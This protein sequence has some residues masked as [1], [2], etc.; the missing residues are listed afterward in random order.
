MTN[1]K[2]LL[3]TLC[4]IIISSISVFSQAN[5]NNLFIDGKF[6]KIIKQSEI[7]INSVNANEL[8]YYW[9]A[10]SLHEK[11]DIKTAISTLKA[12][13]KQFPL[14][15]KIEQL[16]GDYYYEAGN[17]LM[18]KTIFKKYINENKFLFKLCDILEANTSYT[19]AIKILD[20][21]Y[22][23]DS[24]NISCLKHLAH[25]NYKIEDYN[26]AESYYK[27]LITILPNDQ[28][29]SRKLIS[30]YNEQE[31]YEESY[32]LCNKMLKI[33]PEN[34]VFIKLAGYTAIKNQKFIKAKELFTKVYMKGDS[35][36]Y[37]LKHLGLAKL[38]CEQY[39]EGQEILH[40][41]FLK[42]TSDYLVCYFLGDSYL[43]T[44]HRRKGI[45]YIEKSIENLKP[46]GSVMS[47]VLRSNAT[48]HKAIKE[49]ERAIELYLEAFRVGLDPRDIYYAASV[50][51]NG[52]KDYKMALEYFQL[53]L[54]HIS[55]E[56]EEEEDKQ[57]NNST[58][59]NIKMSD[60]AKR[61]IEEIKTE[62]FFREGK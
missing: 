18:A 59:I 7:N 17:L 26:R 31:R 11:G 35:S 3:F 41:A 34:S 16:I 6:E 28:F 45:E 55:G 60:I 52:M 24:I 57:K 20:K 49:Y 30:I 39:K 46:K 43:H 37:V 51:Q 14:S 23:K 62:L 48:L 22:Q 54:N 47:A 58:S 40:K 12:G 15:I 10:Y 50:Y 36:L 8:D 42:D 61:H 13:N 29:S 44:K 25:C 53:F 33:E 5:Y 21:V 56:E 4:L 38:K 27:K 32:N 9:L 19:D 2:S 1:T